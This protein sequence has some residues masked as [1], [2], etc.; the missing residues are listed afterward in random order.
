MFAPIPSLD[1]VAGCN[2]L[3]SAVIVSKGIDH[4]HLTKEWWDNTQ[5]E[6]SE[7]RRQIVIPGYLPFS[8]AGHVI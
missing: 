3:E 1:N 6:E 4:P 2:P 7:L 5:S 8:I